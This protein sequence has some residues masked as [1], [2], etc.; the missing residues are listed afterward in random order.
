MTSRFAIGQFRQ[1]NIDFLP[2][3]AVCVKTQSQETLNTQ[4]NHDYEKNEE[5]IHRFKV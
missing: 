5:E 3:Q 4:C 2:S 1:R